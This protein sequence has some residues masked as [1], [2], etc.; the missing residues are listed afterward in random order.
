M[1]VLRDIAVKASVS[2]TTVSKVLNGKYAD[3]GIS[4]ECAS[5]VRS[6]A[7]ELGYRPNR[8]ARA[9][10]SGRFGMIALLETGC[11]VGLGQM[12]V[13]LLN[14]IESRSRELGLLTAFSAVRA[15]ECKG[16]EMPVFLRESWADGFLIF[17]GTGDSGILAD[18]VS[19]LG[20][21]TVCIGQHDHIDSIFPDEEGAA[22]RATC[23]VLSR[24]IRSPAYIQ[25]NWTTSAVREAREKGYC[26]AVDAAGVKPRI[27]MLPG[28]HRIVERQLPNER[29]KIRLA[30]L[31]SRSLPE[32]VIADSVDIAYPLLH[33]A[34][35][36]GIKV[37]E[38]LSFV[39][40]HDVVANAFGPMIDTMLVRC[41]EWGRK[42][43]DILV[44]KIENKEKCGS[45][46]IE[47]EYVSGDT[48]VQK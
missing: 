3:I 28:E 21:P 33:D 8:A 46:K 9:T 4:D 7:R 23:E 6:V 18:Y 30:F 32:C 26:R 11:N 5:R 42:A 43:V 45:V 35:S 41:G 25:D 34:F 22:Y 27:L 38:N 24:G 17:N 19:S 20:Y 47:Y 29:E 12:P 2:V 16:G 44:S 31:R 48:L 14:G 13:G 10:A 15:N 40:F 36:T 1:V 39:V 37:P